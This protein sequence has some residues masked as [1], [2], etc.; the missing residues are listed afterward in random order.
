M[1]YSLE[2]GYLFLSLITMAIICTIF[3]I[4]SGNMLEKKLLKKAKKVIPNIPGKIFG[5]KG[6]VFIIVTQNYLKCRPDIIDNTLDDKIL[7][8]V[9]NVLEYKKYFNLNDVGYTASSYSTLRNLLSMLKAYAN[10]PEN[11][12]LYIVKNRLGGSYESPA[13]FNIG[14]IKNKY[15]Y[16]LV[17]I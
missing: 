6:R 2:L 10:E 13:V 3:F 11:R 4:V 12:G 14:E 16:Y 8:E 5:Y 17:T 1:E 7:L 9:I 15:T